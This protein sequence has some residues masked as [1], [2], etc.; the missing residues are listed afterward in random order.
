[1]KVK[2]L[3][4]QLK[5]IPEDTEVWLSS[6]EEGNDFNP[7]TEVNFCH[8]WRHSKWEF[9]LIDPDEKDEYPEG[10]VQELLVL[11]P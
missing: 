8:A 4:E 10:E 9:D 6:D 5:D 11:W 1:M 3:I 2:R 7:L